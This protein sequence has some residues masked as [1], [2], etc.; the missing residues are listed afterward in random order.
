[1]ELT[2]GQLFAIFIAVIMLSS[3]LAAVT[4]TG[5]GS[6]N[7]GP[8]AP[9]PNDN[10]TV[11]SY[12]AAGVQAKV[13]QVFPT[14]LIL[15]KTPEFDAANIDAALRKIPGVL[16]VASSQFIGT[17]SDTVNFRAEIRFSSAEKMTGA[18]PS[19]KSLAEFSY[20]EIYPQALAEVPESIEF[21]NADLG[22]TQEYS[23]PNRQLQAYISGATV[24]GDSIAITV[25]AKF[26]GQS[27]SEV[28]AFEEIEQPSTHI[29]QG[30]FKVASLENDFFVR[31]TSPLTQKAKLDAAKLAIEKAADSNSTIQIAQASQ[32]TL[33]YFD[34]AQKILLEDLNTLLSG[35]NG[36][37]SFT[38]RLDQNYVIIQH[39]GNG[40]YAQ[41]KS[42]LESSFSALGLKIS[43][44]Q[45]P[46]VSL[47]G[48]VV[49][50]ADKVVFL[51]AVGA[52]SK[53]I[54]GGI[55]VLQKALVDANSVFVQDANAD[56]AVKGGT[57]P[58]YI[59]PA[60]QIGEEVNLSMLIYGTK[61]LGAL[62]IQAQET[63]E[64]GAQ[65]ITQ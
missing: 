1:M 21:R 32:G 46:I 6:Q 16:L 43:S 24:K 51:A 63:G 5:T 44:V 40:D 12:E 60:H 45:E 9:P 15:A 54:E 17:G 64:A 27:L 4:F 65:L 22:L 33:V 18:I 37:R 34:G 41:F 26:T 62:D 35:F 57:F 42:S 2:G 61:R 52:E 55:E 14:A 20:A 50:A 36:V 11:L 23:F 49:P 38:L 30:A 19:I 53:K 25:Q 7:T 10:T 29:A 3:I 56:F 8:Q 28:I 39:D 31:A 48:T 58:A 59:N 47:Q 13:V